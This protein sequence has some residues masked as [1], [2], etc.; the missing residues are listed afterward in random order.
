M[1]TRKKA[2][3]EE[4]FIR[5]LTIQP[6]HRINRFSQTSVPEIRLCG[7]WL[8]DLGFKIHGKVKL[9][10]SKRLIIIKPDRSRF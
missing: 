5:R 1:R 2:N 9:Q 7:Q 10:T 8:E 3:G 6:K 4:V